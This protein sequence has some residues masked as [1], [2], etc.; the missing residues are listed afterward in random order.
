MG[1]EDQS[2]LTLHR[3]ALWNWPRFIWIFINIVVVATVCYLLVYLPL[4]RKLVLNERDQFMWNVFA[5]FL[6]MWASYQF[7]R[8]SFKRDILE[9]LG[10]TAYGA[11]NRIFEAQAGVTA[12]LDNIKV[13]LSAIQKQGV[14]SP[15]AEFYGERFTDIQHQVSMVANILRYAVLDW[16]SVLPADFEKQQQEEAEFLEAQSEM[17]RLRTELERKTAELE[18]EK[19]A[20]AEIDARNEI[21]LQEI[22]RLDQRMSEQLRK[23]AA[24]TRQ[25][26]FPMG[27]ASNKIHNETDLTPEEI[28]FLRERE[29]ALK[30]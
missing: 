22:A 16:K 7:A 5:L 6:T 2:G 17:A 13:K 29:A 8:M 19:G 11:L 30:K 27:T 23:A 15:S 21:L 20:K 4:A 10:A 1:K 28:A 24:A 12:I 3:M 14:T 9:K 25:A 18:E 26:P